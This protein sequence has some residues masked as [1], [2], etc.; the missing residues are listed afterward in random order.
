LNNKSRRKGRPQVESNGD[1][2]SDAWSGNE[3]SEDE[4]DSGD[5]IRLR[6]Q[7]SKARNIRKAAADNKSSSTSPVQAKK[8]IG[9]KSR[10]REESEEEA[11]SDTLAGND[12]LQGNALEKQWDS[13]IE[14]IEPKEEERDSDIEI[15][16]N[17]GGWKKRRPSLRNP[18]LKRS[19]ALATSDEDEDNSNNK[20]PS[21]TPQPIPTKNKKAGGASREGENR[22]SNRF[23]DV[24][25]YRPLDQAKRAYSCLNLLL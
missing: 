10:Q 15:V 25:F 5:E 21:P 1:S 24:S 4:Q 13:D 9:R 18:S 14:I 19:R 22:Q 16:E 11:E 12:E 7:R 3:Q 23:K 8:T 6:P 2:E 17:P 20:P